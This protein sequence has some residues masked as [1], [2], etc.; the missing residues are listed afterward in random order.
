MAGSVLLAPLDLSAPT[1]VGPRT[2]RKQL[3]RKVGIDYPAPDGSTQRVEFDDAYLT[4][5]ADAFN[6][7]AYDLEPF[8]LA[9]ESNRHTLA[10]ERYHGELLAVEVTADGLDGILELSQEAADLVERTGRRLG[11]SP[12]IRSNIEHVDGRKIKRAIHHVLGT[13]DPRMQGPNHSLSPWQPIDLSADPAETVLDLS[14]TRYQEDT[15]HRLSL[16]HLEDDAL[17]TL[18]SLAAANGIDLSAPDTLEPDG[19]PDAEV[20]PTG[21]PDPDAPD[22]DVEPNNGDDD[23]EGGDEPDGDGITDAELDALIDAELESMG[24]T[25]PD[26]DVSLSADDDTTGD[27]D[28]DVDTVLGR[29]ADG[30]VDLS[31]FEPDEAGSLRAQLAGNQYLAAGVPRY[32]IDLAAPILALPAADDTL[33]LA[34]P[35]DG[36]TVNVR[37]IVTQLL[38][39]MKGTVDLSAEAGH[40]IDIEG[41][42]HVS[43]QAEAWLKHLDA[44]GITN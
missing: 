24:V 42:G 1:R 19:D 4:D 29:R 27:L 41:E 17:E 5:L 13:L 35:L 30:D 15:M 22:A 10:P 11:V 3:L 25:P 6:A 28:D 36:T 44:E 43:P 8:I 39:A 20:T 12:R 40:G 7:G 31:A 34:S 26:G 2:Y 21:E 14:G 18:R 38:D 32:V 9:D 33:D 23:A 37:T 16:D